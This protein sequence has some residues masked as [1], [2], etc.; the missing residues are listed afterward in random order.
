[1]LACTV[2]SKACNFA[3]RVAV[4]PP[5]R[6]CMDAE[7]SLQQTEADLQQERETA[8]LREQFIAVLSFQESGQTPAAGGHTRDERPR[9][10]SADRRRTSSHRLER[11]GTEH[12]AL[13]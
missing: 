3:D 10:G 12:E 1:M 4:P 5:A 11:S 6:K 2:F 13:T 7:E 8:E 9:S